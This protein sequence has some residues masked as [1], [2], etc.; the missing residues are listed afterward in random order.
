MKGSQTVTTK[1]SL[2]LAVTAMFALTTGQGCSG[3][4]GASGTG[5][6]NGSGGATTGTGGAGGGGSGGGGS[7]GS[8][9][10][11][12]GGFVNTGINGELGMGTATPTTYVGTH[13]YQIVGEGGL[14]VPVCEVRFDV[15]RVGAA[16]AACADCDWTH[17]VELSN[18]VVVTN[19][20]GACDANDCVPALDAAGRSALAGTRF[21]LG[22]SQK[23]G[24]GDQVML[25][26][27]NLMMWIAAGPGHWDAASGDFGYSLE[28]SGGFC[29]YGH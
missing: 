22:S 13:T 6:A 18:P 9:G 14:G 2:F 7:G 4:G 16:T 3:G 17:L 24:H 15:N 27:D 5:G 25:Y 1:A 12:A 10:S 19:T 29:N 21:Q 11:G 26:D 8:G 28:S 20:D 23:A